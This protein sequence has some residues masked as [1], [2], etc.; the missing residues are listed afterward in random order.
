MLKS[1]EKEKKKDDIVCVCR[2]RERVLR[3]LCWRFRGYHQNAQEEKGG[4]AF[5]ERWEQPGTRW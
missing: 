5:L 4:L 1:I 2:E 3:V